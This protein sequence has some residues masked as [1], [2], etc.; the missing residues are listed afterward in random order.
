MA[1]CKKCGTELL[2]KAKICDRCGQPVFADSQTFETYIQQ[3][4]ESGAMDTSD[5]TLLRVLSVFIAITFILLCAGIGG[6]IYI[7]RAVDCPEN[8]MIPAPEYNRSEYRINFIKTTAAIARADGRVYLYTMRD[9]IRSAD[10][11]N[12]LDRDFEITAESIEETN[13]LLRESNEINRDKYGVRWIL[14][15]WAGYY[16]INVWIFGILWVLLLSFWF[17][18][19]GRLR[20]RKDTISPAAWIFVIG[21][22]LVAVYCFISPILN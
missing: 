13:K 22:I 19:G 20:N 17:M 12:I 7:G 4:S 8:E 14:F 16:I 5:R 3:P 18:K 1:F 10:P 2:K 11:D 6:L 15:Q 9:L 21:P